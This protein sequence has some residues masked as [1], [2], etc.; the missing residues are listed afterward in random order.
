MA[1]SEEYGGEYNSDVGEEHEF[2]KMTLETDDMDPYNGSS[3][4]SSGSDVEP[5]S[6]KLE[7]DKGY[8]IRYLTS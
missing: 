1:E 5:S 6:D 7:A 8:K 3:K 4:H 2:M